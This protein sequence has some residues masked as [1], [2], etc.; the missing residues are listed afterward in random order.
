MRG[1]SRRR[2]AGLFVYGGGASASPDLPSYTVSRRLIASLPPNTTHLQFKAAEPISIAGYIMIGINII[3][4]FEAEKSQRGT[5]GGLI[6]PMLLLPKYGGGS[7]FE[8][9]TLARSRR[10][11]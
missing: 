6:T 8:R 2:S 1:G 9:V 10:L 7:L 5:R 3:T 11:L 4:I